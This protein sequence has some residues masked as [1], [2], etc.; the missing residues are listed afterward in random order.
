MYTKIRQKPSTLALYAEQCVKQ[1]VLTDDAV[2]NMAESYRKAL[3]EGGTVL[4]VISEKNH[5]HEHG[6][7]W[8]PFLGKSWTEPAST[9][10]P[11][12]KLQGLARTL[13]AFPEDLHLQKQ[14][15]KEMDNRLKMA[16]GE[17]PMNW[18]FAETLAYASLLDE[19][20]RI[21]LCGQD[22]CGQNSHSLFQNSLLRATCCFACE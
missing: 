11:M 1:N 10:L 21:R 9:H 4:E 12:E 8:T 5:E 17:L 18:G 3:D 6:M 2:K 14:V 16:E 15:K 19:G 7:D 22:S 20:H 13:C